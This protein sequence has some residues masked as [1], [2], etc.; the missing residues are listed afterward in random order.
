MAIR[1]AEG[2]EATARTCKELQVLTLPTC[3]GPAVK[4]ADIESFFSDCDGV[5]QDLTRMSSATAI[6]TAAGLK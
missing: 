1:N 3:L 5:A 6:G 4:L 2:D